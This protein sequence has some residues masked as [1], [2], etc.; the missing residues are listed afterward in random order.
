MA[1]SLANLLEIANGEEKDSTQ[2]AQRLS[3]LRLR[4]GQA[5]HTEKGT[6]RN[7]CATNRGTLAGWKPALPSSGRYLACMY[8][9]RMSFV[10]A[11]GL[12]RL[13]EVKSSVEPSLVR[14]AK[15]D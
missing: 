7:R 12:A 8:L 2:S 6:A 9:A 14:A 11:R 4:S 10:R 15:T 3:T 13:V 1:L 5:E